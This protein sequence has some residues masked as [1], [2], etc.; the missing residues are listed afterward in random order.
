[1]GECIDN[2]T[3]F[4]TIGVCTI[5]HIPGLQTYG[6]TNCFYK[7]CTLQ[8]KTSEKVVSHILYIL[9]YTEGDGL[10]PHPLTHTMLPFSPRKFVWAR[11]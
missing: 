10:D 9:T 1:M 5:V 6:G 11:R 2:L 3:S 4:L 8:D 7:G